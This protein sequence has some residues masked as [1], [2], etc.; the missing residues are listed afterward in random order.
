M[1]KQDNND[2]RYASFT[3]LFL[4][5]E[6]RIRRFVR[7]LLTSD[8]EV[9]DVLQEVALVAWRKYSESKDVKDFGSWACVIARYEV[10][11]WRRKHA[12]DRLVF[13]EDTLR[14]LA[15]T[16]MENID[17]RERECSALE[18]C[19]QKLSKFERALVM[20][21]HTPGASV[22]RIAEETGQQARRLYRR[23]SGLRLALLNCVKSQLA[24][25]ISNG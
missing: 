6:R 5:H 21:V 8:A 22:A 2:Q 3:R 11:K 9:D 13:R 25:G 15:D 1:S 20:S 16:E 10:L 14:L 4:R 19:L 23:V 12:R 24:E 7:V 18:Q 17:Q